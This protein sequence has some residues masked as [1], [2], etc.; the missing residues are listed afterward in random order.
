MLCSIQHSD[1]EQE[2]LVMKRMLPAV[3]VVLFLSLLITV[4]LTN[5]YNAGPA[6]VLF[7]L[8]LVFT[9]SFVLTLILQNFAVNF[10]VLSISDSS[11]AR[12]YSGLVVA[13]GVTYLVAIQTVGQ[14]QSVDLVLVI[15][16]ELMANFYIHRRL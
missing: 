7:F 16:F 10:K 8:I 5:P 4:I 3:F 2:A 13:T 11:V 14:L 6:L 12:Y 9:F 15:I 1:Q